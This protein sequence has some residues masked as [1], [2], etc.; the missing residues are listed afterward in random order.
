MFDMTTFSSTAFFT[1][2]SMTPRVTLINYYYCCSVPIYWVT[3]QLYIY[4]KNSQFKIYIIDSN[5]SALSRS[6]WRSGG[7]SFLPREELMPLNVVVHCFCS[8]LLSCLVVSIH[9]VH[10]FPPSPGGPHPLDKS[11]SVSQWV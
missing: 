8:A 5:Y 2:S 3:G 11:I 1:C 6:L 10:E 7:P 9:A 4:I